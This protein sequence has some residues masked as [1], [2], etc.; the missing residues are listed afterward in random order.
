MRVV[1]QSG[2]YE[3][4]QAIIVATS[5][6]QL[7]ATQALRDV[8]NWKKIQFFPSLIVQFSENS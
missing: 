4:G 5:T 2:V 6:I 1:L 7:N 8:W 3:V